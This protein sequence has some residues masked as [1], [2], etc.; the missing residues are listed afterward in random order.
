MAK[1]VF[2]F[3]SNDAG[4][5]GAGAAQEA[6]KKYGARWG[7]SYGHYGDSFAIP[8]KDEDIQTLH[9]DRIKRYVNGFIAY[10]QGHPKLTF[11]VTQIGCG[12][13]GYKASQIAPLFYDA[14][15]NCEFDSAWSHYLGGGRTYWGEF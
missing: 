1:S 13:A 7:K 8:T 14:P 4:I 9:L 5:H 6:Y 3:G 15:K 12:R 11:K 10:A 2:V